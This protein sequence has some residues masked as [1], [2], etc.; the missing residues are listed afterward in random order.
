MAAAAGDING[1]TMAAAADS[2]NSLSA[3]TAALTLSLFGR[4]VVNGTWHP[5]VRMSDIYPQLAPVPVP[6]QAVC[7]KSKESFKRLALPYLEAV[8]PRAYYIAMVSERHK[9]YVCDAAR[10]IT[11][12]EK[13]TEAR[14]QGNLRMMQALPQARQQAQEFRNINP[15]AVLVHTISSMKDEEMYAAKKVH[16]F[17]TR[18]N[19]VFAHCMKFTSSDESNKFDVNYIK[20]LLLA[21][22]LDRSDAVQKARMDLICHPTTTD[23]DALHLLSLWFHDAADQKEGLQKLQQFICK[24]KE[25]AKSEERLG[26]VDALFKDYPFVQDMLGELFWK[27]EAPIKKDYERAAIH[28]QKALDKKPDLVN[29]L[30]GLGDSLRTLGKFKEAEG[31]LRK[32]LTLNP[33]YIFVVG[34]L[35]VVLQLQGETSEAKTH[36]DLALSSQQNREQLWQNNILGLVQAARDAIKS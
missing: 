34:I 24:A 26:K 30:A 4:R 21:N 23:D 18:G 33:N 7:E 1:S 16:I 13:E 9:D 31:H 36:L 2:I 14:Q 35:G 12:L 3:E 20:K 29:S 15:T 6:I 28:Y 19:P 17:V 8:P 27:G 11:D 32:A 22:S 25:S 5:S 10:F